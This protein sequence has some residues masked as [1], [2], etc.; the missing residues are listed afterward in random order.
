[1]ASGTFTIDPAKNGVG[2][3][4]YCDMATLGGGW[5]LLATSSDDGTDTWTWDNRHYFD[6]DRTV[7]GDVQN[8]NRDFK[9]VAL[10][11]LPMD[12]VLFVHQPSGITAMYNISDVPA[13]GE[14]FGAMIARKGRSCGAR[15]TTG[16]YSL[17]GGSLTRKGS[18]CSTR[19]FISPYDVD[20]TSMHYPAAHPCASADRTGGSNNAYGPAFSAAAN[21]GCPLDDPG[22]RSSLGPTEDGKTAACRSV[23]Y[24]YG[25]DGN[26]VKGLGFGWAIGANTGSAG[27]AQNFIQIYAR[28]TKHAKLYVVGGANC[29]SGSCVQVVT[30]KSGDVFNPGT[31][32]WSPIAPM[33]TVRSGFAM[34]AVA[35]KMI[36]LGGQDRHGG[37]W[38]SAEMYHPATNQWT[39][40]ASMIDQRY[41]PGATVLKGQVYALGGYSPSRHATGSD[42]LNTCEVYDLHRNKWTAIAPMKIAGSGIQAVELG[43]KIYALGGWCGVRGG[44]YHSIRNVQVYDPRTRQ[45]S[46]AAPMIHMRSTFPAIVAA[47][48]IYVVG[49][50]G[51]STMAEVYSPGANKWTAIAPLPQS[52]QYVFGAAMGGQ[53]FALGGTH[54]PTRGASAV[55]LASTEIYNPAT[56]QWTRGPSMP[57]QRYDAEAVVLDC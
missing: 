41:D 30:L 45:W 56:N 50:D 3:E 6:T 52:R 47:G 28:R 55:A 40:I 42:Y 4:V 26:K 25:C 22:I 39:S 43:G 13:G 38:R 15:A 27:A 29:P 44:S 10:H 35:G 7:F 48:K 36:A 18:L 9:S 8:R 21:N 23:E 37:Y 16:F 34:V 31:D 33:G 2:F 12:Q 11:D 54:T 32:R 51:T 14:S 17:T 49:G 53:L 24:S 46:L 20:G 1:M 19:L 5:T 57:H